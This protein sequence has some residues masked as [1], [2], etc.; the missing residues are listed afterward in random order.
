MKDLGL[1][2][3]AHVTAAADV[4]VDPLARLASVSGNFPSL[5]R[6]LSKLPVDDRLRG[7]VGRN[8]RAVGSGEEAILV[9][10][11]MLDITSP[12][13]NV[14][15]LLKDLTSETTL[16]VRV[17]TKRLSPNHAHTAHG[18]GLVCLLRFP[19]VVPRPA[20]VANDVCSAAAAAFWRR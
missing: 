5:A 12:S 8:H 2:A 15:Q 13:F 9:N 1:Q 11:R 20:C 18:C 4:G 14:F 10:G 19:G 17:C 16:I 7:E 6:W 3:V